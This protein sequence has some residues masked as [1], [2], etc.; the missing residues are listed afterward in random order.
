MM[1]EARVVSSPKR[2]AGVLDVPGDKSLSHR[3]LLLNAMAEGVASVTNLLWGADCLS[4]IACLKRLGVNIEESQEDGNQGSER[5]PPTLTVRGVGAKGFAEPADVLD[6]GNSGTTMRLLTGILA[7]QPFLSILTGDASL[8]SRPMARVIM[9]LRM[10]GAQI[11]GRGGDTL[12]PLAIRG[13]VL[14]GIEYELPVA[15]AQLK[16]AL[17]L[18]GLRARGR[19]TVIEPGPSRDHT[20]RMLKAMGAEIEIEGRRITLSPL[21]RPL[22]CVDFS[23]PGDMSS[24]AFWLVAGTIHPQAHLSLRNVGVNPT[25][26]GILDALYAMGANISLQHER[27]VGGEPV[28]DIVVASSPLRGTEISGDLVPRLLDE[29]PVLAVAA[30]M[31]DGVTTI[32][33]ATELRVKESDRLA[34]IA[35]G[36]TS[37]GVTVEELHD[38]LIIHGSRKLR[39]ARCATHHDHRLAMAFAIAGLVASGQT[40]IDD[41]ACVDISYPAFWSDLDQICDPSAAL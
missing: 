16:S 15:S 18:A 10:M 4:T 29:V 22:H 1:S 33:D 26:T 31:A 41:A 30:S 2:L 25:R 13:S 3:A 19:T 7:G 38:G 14:T 23:I 35:A 40:I 21:A 32:R 5:T 6:A 37:L 17:L 28:A 11:W 27:L 24:A 36:L 8:R 9:P 34:G 12:A 39:G 20:E